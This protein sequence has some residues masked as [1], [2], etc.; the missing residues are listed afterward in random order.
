ML[1]VYS[2]SEQAPGRLLRYLTILGPGPADIGPQTHFSGPHS[3]YPSR[4][5]CIRPRT[6]ICCRFQSP[7]PFS[8]DH[9]RHGHLGWTAFGPGPYSAA[10]I[11]P[12]DYIR[13][14]TKFGTTPVKEADIFG[15]SIP[16]DF[17]VLTFFMCEHF[18]RSDLV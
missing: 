10:D 16:R 4:S 2:I 9:I 5:D 3:A 6:I 7:G 1:C 13:A 11:S 18:W 8:P 15:I 14:R 17:K 12:P